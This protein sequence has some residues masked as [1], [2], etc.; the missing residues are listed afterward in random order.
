MSEKSSFGSIRWVYERG[1]GVFSDAGELTC[2]DGVIVDVTE[3]REAQ[4]AVLSLESVEVLHQEVQMVVLVE[5]Q[6]EVN[7]Q[8]VE[9][10]T[11]VERVQVDPMAEME[12]VVR[13]L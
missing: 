4:E 6:V 1:Q 13:S 2:L 11:R 10:V 3:Q 5:I 12:Q 9:Q 7:P 8:E